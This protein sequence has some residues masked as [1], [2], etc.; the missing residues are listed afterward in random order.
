MAE[1]INYKERFKGAVKYTDDEAL[2]YHRG[3]GPGNGK[4]EVC[5]TSPLKTKK[6]LSLA[7][8]PGVAVPCKAIA[9]DKAKVYDYTTKGN[10]VAVVT[11]GTAVLGLG[12]IGPEAG[13]PVMEGKC[14]LFKN[15]AGV[16]AIP[17]CLNTQDTEEIISAVQWLE[18][19]FGGIN[20]EDISAPRCFEIEQRLKQS[21]DIPVFHDDQHGT[22]IVT[23]AGLINAL[24]VVGKDIKDVRV[25]FNGAGAGGIAC[26]KFYMSAGVKDVILCDSKGPIYEG[27]KEGMNPVKEEMAKITN[28]QNIQ[29]SLAQAMNGADIFVGLS[30]AGCVNKDMVKSMA[31]DAIVFACANPVP[32]IMPEDA[33]A[34]GATVVATGRSDYANQIN[35][36]LGF[37]GIF[38]GALDVRAKDINEEM[39]LAASNAIA[40][41]I[42]DDELDKDYIITNPLDP[43]VMPTEAAA[44]AKA[45][46][47]SGVARIKV[48][49]E[50]V[51]ERT[52]RLVEEARRRG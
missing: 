29:R 2:S 25:V 24:K 22:A 50:E 27:R 17:I 4:I 11:D 36:V 44:V 23:L 46:M 6:D 5:A 28:K 32:E 33:L 12:N 18:P 16:D 15:L 14:V 37:P 31:D 51:K 41:A 48:N 38:R 19:G 26:A 3:N 49:P 40:S 30:V 9:A 1:E 8:T 52:A 20:L 45:A 39:K 35:N 34:A 42:S 7:Y 47:D 13:L 43:R 21:L 10:M